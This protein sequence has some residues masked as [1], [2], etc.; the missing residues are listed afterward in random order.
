L[1][2][3]FF[4]TVKVFILLFVIIIGIICKSIM[5]NSKERELRLARVLKL[6]NL[7]DQS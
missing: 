4:G 7:R 6:G 2:N 3:N 5:S 1:L